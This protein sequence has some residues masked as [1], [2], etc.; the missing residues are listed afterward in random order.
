MIRLH[1][2]FVRAFRLSAP[3]TGLL[4]CAVLLGAC[5]AMPLDIE[6]Q[7]N[8]GALPATPGA[9]VP[10][11]EA[12]AP[13]VATGP[14]SKI[15][16][17]LLSDPLAAEPREVIA[18]LDESAMP[19]L[20]QTKPGTAN[21][22]SLQGNAERFGIAQD[23]LLDRLRDERVT[24]THRYQNLPAMKVRVDSPEALMALAADPAV[25]RVVRNEAHS[26]IDVPSPALALIKQPSA[27]SAGNLG[28][29][30]TVAVLDTGTNYKTAPFNCAA[31]GA[32]NCP[33]A[34]AADFAPED[35]NVDDNGHGT[36]VSGIVLSVAP[37]AK[38]VAL[39]VFRGA[40]GM[41]TDIM[42]A[43]DWCIANRA[44]YNIV[45]INMSLGGGSF[46]SACAQDALAVSVA[47]ARAAG[48]LSAIATGNS[49][50]TNA[51]SSPA[52]APDAVSVGAVHA[53]NLG[54]MSW[55]S[56]SDSTTAADKVA[57]FSNSSAQM[58]ILAPGVQI[59]AAGI[60][61]SGTS[62]ATPH[63]AGAIAVLRSAFPAETPTAI[64]SR[65]TSYGVP[66]KDARNGL[67]KPRLDL[68]AS[69]NGAAAAPA[70]GTSPAPVPTP[71][72]DPGPTGTITLNN[73]A[74]FTKS[75]TV[76]AALATTSG[77]ATQVCMSE[78]SSCAKWVTKASA[79]SVILSTGNGSKTVNVWWKNAAGTISATPASASIT[80][81]STAPVDGTLSGTANVLDVTF[82]WSGFTD[83][84]AGLYSYRLLV[85]TAAIAAGC[86]T[87]TVA[88]EGPNTSFSKSFTAAGTI[89]ARVC[90][91]DAL[92]TMSA[93]KTIS[94][95]LVIPPRNAMVSPTTATLRMGSE[96][97][98]TSFEDACPAGQ[99]LIGFSG[100]TSTATTAA[101]HRQI[102]GKCGVV[103]TAGPKVTI[104]AAAALPTRGSTGT[105]AWSRTCPANQVV[106][107]FAGRSSTVVNQLSIVC[108][109][110]TAASMT[111]GAAV[112]VGTAAAVAGVGGTGGIAVAAIKCGTG[113][114]ATMSRVRTSANL[115]AFG[116]GCGRITVG[117]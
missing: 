4:A 78:S 34:Y 85:G 6:D 92:G 44:K 73:G 19:K 49:G 42:S 66:V 74:L 5:E 75:S 24:A 2:G 11:N 76:T 70:P 82:N 54:G 93:G 10:S 56:C 20:A 22:F 87:G 100:S 69:L 21:V 9:A 112:N 111:A 12:Q 8:A 47:S 110:L 48:I 84:G 105:A 88:Y 115:D 81:D 1:P 96:A 55:G 35:N 17:R 86:A 36:N 58:T 39:D 7:R 67:T 108:A 94:M 45:A 68:W 25:A 107:G 26:M 61:M 51:I 43:I 38:I 29:G 50:V 114:V 116:L 14:E 60:T 23:R 16:P 113:E 18:L 32:T 53:A 62:Q 91:K 28:A 13:Q 77:T 72:P 64:V 52:C 65:L 109:P 41:T 89:F 27:A 79:F 106:V 102:T 71:A 46:G 97:N 40:S 90:A 99:V 95:A 31:A 80:V 117:N 83:A 101:V 103:Q 59:N 3:R 33:I 15:D 30:A 37:S 63:V 98:G 104:T 57:C